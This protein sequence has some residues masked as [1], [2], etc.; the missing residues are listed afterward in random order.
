MKRKLT[1]RYLLEMCSAILNQKASYILEGLVLT[2]TKFL[3]KWLLIKKRVLVKLIK[4]ICSLSFYKKFLTQNLNRKTEILYP[5]RENQQ[6]IF[7]GKKVKM[8]G[9]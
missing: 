8:V 7:V 6:K 4:L 2:S 9:R 1:E 5:N 3:I